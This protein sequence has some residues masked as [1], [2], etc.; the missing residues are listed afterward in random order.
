MHRHLYL[1]AKEEKVDGL[2]FRHLEQKDHITSENYWF[3]TKSCNRTESN[4]SEETH[5]LLHKCDCLL[6]LQVASLPVCFFS[7]WFRGFG[8]D[9]QHIRTL[10]CYRH[11]SPSA[12]FLWVDCS[13]LK[14]QA[15][16][17]SSPANLFKRF[18][19]PHI[20]N[21]SWWLTIANK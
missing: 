17:K 19:L 18:V 16:F 14:F 12:F 9:F 20:L 4:F 10:D 21:S 15:S 2:I 8:Q 7:L 5:C 11:H 3:G 1:S 13:W 6:P